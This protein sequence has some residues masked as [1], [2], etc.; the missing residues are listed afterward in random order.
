MWLLLLMLLLGVLH[1]I[2]RRH[3]LHPPSHRPPQ[4]AGHATVEFDPPKVRTRLPNTAWM[5]LMIG[6]A[7]LRGRGLG[8]RIVT[9][10]EGRAR[11]GGAAR[12]EVAVFG[13]NAPSLALFKGLGYAEVS[14]TPEQIYWDGRL[15]DDVRLVKPLR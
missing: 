2:H 3:G 13:F 14:R 8:K 7:D 10:L 6:E 1:S 15:W 12:I 5:A 11:E 4:P 9:D